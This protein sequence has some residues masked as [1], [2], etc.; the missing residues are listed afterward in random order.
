[1]HMLSQ[2]IQSTRT[3]PPVWQDETSAVRNLQIL[4]GNALTVDSQPQAWLGM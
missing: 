2:D 4:A 3:A 1:M